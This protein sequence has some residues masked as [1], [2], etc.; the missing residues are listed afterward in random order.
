MVHPIARAWC[1][2]SRRAPE[3]RVS[4]A[5]SVSPS[6]TDASFRERDRMPDEG[7]PSGSS[8]ASDLWRVAL[9]DGR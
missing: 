8:G 4:G 5:S 9:T 1:W 3:H 6:A 7:E 2:A